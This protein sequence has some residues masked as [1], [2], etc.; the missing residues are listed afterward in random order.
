MSLPV[1]EPVAYLQSAETDRSPVRA[2]ALARLAAERGNLL[3]L[4]LGMNSEALTEAAVPGEW[5]VKDVLAHMAGW[6]RWMART[7]AAMEAGED[8]R[9]SDLQD[10]DAANEALVAPWRDRSLDVMLDELEAARS[11][12]VRFLIGLPESAFLRERACLGQDWSFPNLLY[13]IAQHDAEHAEQL[14][15]WRAE[16]VP[17]EGKGPKAALVAALVAAREELLT[18]AALVAPADRPSR[19]V[20][21][22][23]TLKDLLAH[24]ADWE[25]VGLEGL[26]CMAR[27]EPP[28]VEHI[29]DI[30]A[31]NQEQARMRREQPWEPIWDDLEKTR[32][33]FLD[34]L[35]GMSQAAI[36]ATY[37]FPWGSHGTAYQWGAVFVRHDREHAEALRP[38]EMNWFVGS[39]P[40]QG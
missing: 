3:E 36:E 22:V 20:C 40:V 11:G 9:I 23:W 32:H 2:H 16:T 30:D 38:R 27:R 10:T 26:R 14:L 29:D 17:K 19:A 15:A 6:D 28:D 8:P 33:A 4:L 25:L 1:T 24:I 18:A 21:G 37:P 35:E 13:G 5:T 39:A 31:W 34:A 7:M 12:W